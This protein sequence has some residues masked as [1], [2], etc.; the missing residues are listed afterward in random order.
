MI[1]NL[2]ADLPE[3]LPEELTSVLQADQ[4][5]RIERIIS[6]GHASPDGFWYDQPGHEW[7]IVLK[8]AVRIDLEDSTVEMMPGDY[9]NIPA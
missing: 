7:V 3:D 1:A 4:A 8:G 9:I 6:H 5:L 2:F